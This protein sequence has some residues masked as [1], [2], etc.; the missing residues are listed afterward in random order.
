MGNKQNIKFEIFLEN[1]EFKVSANESARAL[2]GLGSKADDVGKKGENGF[3]KFG[4]AAIVAKKAI[5]AFVAVKLVGYVKGLASSFLS[6][7]ASFEKH[8][9]AFE[10]MLGSAKKA[11]TLLKDIKKFSGSTPFQLDGLLNASKQ[12]LAFGIAEED[13]IEKMRNLGNAA[14][15]NQEVFE[16]LAGA[17]GKIKAKGKASL[18]ELNQLTEAGV[19]IMQELAKQYD[20]TT[21]EL[22]KLVE[23]G[24]VGFT[25]VD[26]ALSGLTT[27]SG[28][29]AG[30]LQ[31]QSQSLAGLWSTL[32]DKMHLAFIEIGDKMAP[33]FK[34]LITQLSN[35]KIILPG[36]IKMF[37]LI[38][39]VVGGFAKAIS[40]AVQGVEDI[41]DVFAAKD[42]S[43]QIKK[44]EEDLKKH[45]RIEK[46]F[47]DKT[48]A[49]KEAFNNK[50]KRL[51]KKL[52]EYRIEDYKNKI[53]IYKD[54][55]KSQEEYYDKFYKTNQKYILKDERNGQGEKVRYTSEL[56]RWADAINESKEDIKKAYIEIRKEEKKIKDFYSSEEK[57]YGK[58]KVGRKIDL[59]VGSTKLDFSNNESKPTG[60]SG[61]GCDNEQKTKDEKEADCAE[62][63]EKAKWERIKDV[64]S[65]AKDY[66]SETISG[67]GDAYQLL[68][69]NTMAR[70]DNEA[71][72]HK[73]M[74]DEK[75]GS[76][77]E[78]NQAL[79][80]L[81][82]DKSLSDE[83]RAEREEALTTS[84]AE[85]DKKRRVEEAVFADELEKK[86]QKE[87]V[88]NAKFQKK[89]ALMQ[90]FVDVPAA[91][92]ATFRNMGGWPWGIVPAA[93]MSGIGAVKIN[94]IKNT[95]IPS[96]DVGNFDIPRDHVA[97][98]HK[99]EIIT[100]ATMSEQIRSGK[101]VLATPD[102]FNKNG[103]AGGVS[104]FTFNIPV[105]VEIDGEEI[106]EV[107]TARQIKMAS[108]KGAEINV[109]EDV[110]A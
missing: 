30:T 14:Q 17:Y 46:E 93:I 47:Q 91:V 26:K 68:H 87:Q 37:S 54:N 95:P 108:D 105:S 27:G 109:F 48:I 67:I 21:G 58:K 20:V 59:R 110:Y 15:G 43:K 6:A 103:G 89:I 99:G 5:V 104:N 10:T 83:T 55:I 100:P 63:A 39:N 52:S 36:I 49:E 29:F 107:V 64:V 80:D 18:E 75:Y 33:A 38:G 32:K 106:T 4:N 72:A 97:N 84:K 40:Y 86:K 62:Q 71:N 28:K 60:K 90:A 69:E 51:N 70:F 25:D 50:G 78:Y 92:M 53:K 82:N 24:K 76:D 101:A 11:K 66:L 9:I 57:S 22:F 19:P 61:S 8:R 73:R 96:Y 56:K 45:K 98:V 79:L 13:I 34:D 74:M 16:R 42:R 44:L 31:K 94:A 81:Q 3:K 23:T 41:G 102:Y 12:L 35:S 85:K 7:S 65:A 77:V 88:K 2:A 1:G